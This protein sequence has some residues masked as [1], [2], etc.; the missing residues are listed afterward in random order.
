[1]QPLFAPVPVWC[2]PVSGVLQCLSDLRW[3]LYDIRQKG[4]LAAVFVLCA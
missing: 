3:R 4:H 2:A 1:M